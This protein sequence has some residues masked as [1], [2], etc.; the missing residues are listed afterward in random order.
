MA[1]IGE[2]N[3]K[4]LHAALKSACAQPG[5]RFEVP[6]DGYVVDIVRGGLLVE[7]QTGNFAAIK[8]KLAKLLQTHRLRLVYPIPMEKWLVKFDPNNGDGPSRR[9]SPKRGRLEDLFSEL[10][11]IPH[12][13]T[14]PNF[15]LEVLL[16]REEEVRRYV[17]AS[18]G[19]RHWR[20][21]GWLTEERRLLAVID[22]HLFEAPAELGALLP[23][24]LADTFT[25]QEIAEAG[26]IRR[27][28]AQRMAYCL[29]HME[30]I[31]CIGKQQ[32]AYLYALAESFTPSNGDRTP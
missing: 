22:R 14:H 5:D 28:L 3:E 19:R 18:A 7:I 17:G 11:R 24:G 4:P 32:R 15:S 30:V 13:M 16:T 23:A 29:R 1:S 6:V 25:T 9:K 10:V 20:K 26:K 27:P 8:K 12:L 2:L 31:E 21:R